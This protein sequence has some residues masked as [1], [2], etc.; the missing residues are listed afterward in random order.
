[1][2]PAGIFGSLR[3]KIPRNKT[4]EP[5]QTRFQP[6][7]IPTLPCNR[8]SIL[9][10]TPILKPDHSIFHE[11]DII[12]ELCK[13]VHSRQPKPMPLS[14]ANDFQ[15]TFHARLG[16]THEPKHEIPTDPLNQMLLSTGLDRKG[17]LLNSKDSIPEIPENQKILNSKGIHLS[18]PELEKMFDMFDDLHE[19][20]SHELKLKIKNK[21]PRT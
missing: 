7:P 4:M 17:N 14:K 15:S 2:E 8:N 13:T 18:K 6:I 1:M 9:V 3:I 5:I 10:F 11:A 21:D 12:T 20:F 19:N 16:L